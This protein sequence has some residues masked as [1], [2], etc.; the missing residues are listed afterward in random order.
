MIL[1]V[2]Y[3]EYSWFR[4]APLQ[5]FILGIPSNFI[6]R[7]FGMRFLFAYRSITKVF[8]S[9]FTSTS[10]MLSSARGRNVLYAQKLLLSLWSSL[11]L[12]LFTFI[13]RPG[14]VLR[15]SHVAIVACLSIHRDLKNDIADNSHST[16]FFVPLAYSSHYRICTS[17][18]LH[19]NQ[20][21]RRAVGARSDQADTSSCFAPLSHL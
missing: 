1:L 19:N 11:Q 2:I 7:S 18:T 15:L 3:A 9:A 8:C 4:L 5:T 14:R 16:R 20:A 17:I 13:L 6:I 21:W 12:S 10:S